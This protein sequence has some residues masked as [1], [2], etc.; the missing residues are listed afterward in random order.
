MK[1]F[2]KTLIV[3]G[4][5][6]C[7]ALYLLYPRFAAARV[8]NP[9]EAAAMLET[10]LRAGDT[11]ETVFRTEEIDLDDVYT[12]LEA[13]YPYSFALRATTRPGGTT[14][15]VVEVSRPVRQDEARQYAKTLAQSVVTEDMDETA[16]LRALHDAL[17]RQCRYDTDT[18][19]SERRVGS[20]APFAADGALLDHK[21]VCAGY[22][23]AYA[24]LCEAVGIRAVYVT[25]EEMDH[26]WN[27]VR[28]NGTTYYI[29]CTFDDPVPDRGE[30]VFSEYF[31]RTGDEL[32]KTH[33]W[34]RSFYERL[35]DN[36]G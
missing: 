19:E 4:A 15:L 28:L 29:D 6:A 1:R 35:L 14:A 34:D 21:A 17:I 26:G 2:G 9:Y 20:S 7:V 8:Q 13:I 16:K 27:A 25:S 23:R 30:Y 33:V 11:G 3:L 32:A 31:M 24:M 10:A 36:L 18:A 22:G 5:V 12:A